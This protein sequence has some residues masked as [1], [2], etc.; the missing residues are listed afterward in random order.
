MDLKEDRTLV[1]SEDCSEGS[2][3]FLSGCLSAC[4][5]LLQFLANHL[6]DLEVLANA[7]VN[8]DT[9][10]LVELSFRKPGANTF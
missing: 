10:A 4:T 8:A 9:F 7:A 5:H 2:E 6:V 1:L 3:C